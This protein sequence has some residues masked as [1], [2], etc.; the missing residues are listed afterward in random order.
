MDNK[1]KGLSLVAGGVVIAIAAG[2]T[3]ALWNDSATVTGGEITSG[4]LD[5]AVAAG[6]WEDVSLANGDIGTPEADVEDMVSSAG[7]ITNLS[8]F[9]MVPGD[10]VVGNFATTVALEGNHA[11]A[12]LEVNLNE[13]ITLPTG[14]AVDYRL[15]G[16]AWTALATNNKILFVAPDGENASTF[17]AQ[18]AGQTAIAGTGDT[19]VDLE[20]RVYFDDATTGQ[21]SV[22]ST[23]DLTDVV[24]TLTQ[25]R[26]ADLDLP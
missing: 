24:V 15:D 1:K 10:T 26:E 5:L 17:G 23:V 2:G 3:F 4:N 11:F 22:Q 16:G 14:F 8:A 6:A 21:T 18:V 25:V 9:R 13:G 12:E 19:T 7:L 20:I